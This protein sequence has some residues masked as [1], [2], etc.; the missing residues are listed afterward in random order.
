[1]CIYNVIVRNQRGPEIVVQR[2]D[3][4]LHCIFRRIYQ[5]CIL[6][7][8]RIL[9]L[10][11]GKGKANRDYESCFVGWYG[12]LDCEISL[13]LIGTYLLVRPKGT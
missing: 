5:Y 10:P 13:S 1:M 2:I 7:C 8:E 4:D 9:L 6:R 11:K 3:Q 12:P